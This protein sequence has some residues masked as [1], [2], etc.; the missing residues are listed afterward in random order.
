MIAR[1]Q[2]RRQSIVLA[3]SALKRTYRTRLAEGLDVTFV[4][5][6]ANHALIEGRLRQRAGHF[7]NPGLLNSQLTTLEEPT[8]DEQAIEVDASAAPET[9]LEQIESELNR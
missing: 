5:L 6:K 9:I 1:S 4:Y 7:M 8:E 2:A 3:C